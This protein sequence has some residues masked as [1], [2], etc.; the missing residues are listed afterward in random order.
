MESAGLNISNQVY[1]SKQHEIYALSFKSVI[2]AMKF[3][4][5]QPI[6]QPVIKSFMKKVIIYD[7]ACC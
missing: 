5:K 6:L 7:C 2:E 1:Y 4:N 3:V